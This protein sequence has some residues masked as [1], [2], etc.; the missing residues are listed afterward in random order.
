ML[1]PYGNTHAWHSGN[2]N[3]WTGAAWSQSS[4]EVFTVVQAPT[5]GSWRNGT[6]TTSSNNRIAINRL[7]TGIEGI[8]TGESM[9]GVISEIVEVNAVLSAAD[10]QLLERNQGVYF[11]VAVA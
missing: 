9:F 8:Y 3:H 10:R 4:L 7:G 5:N 11:S 6:A 1:G 2:W